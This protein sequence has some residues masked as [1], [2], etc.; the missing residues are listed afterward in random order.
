MGSPLAAHGSR[1][2]HVRQRTQVTGIVD[3]HGCRGQGA[4]TSQIITFTGQI[5]YIDVLSNNCLTGIFAAGVQIGDHYFIGTRCVV[6]GMSRIVTA[7][8]IGSP[9]IRQRTQITGVVDRHGGRGQQAVTSQIITGA[10][11][12]RRNDVLSNNCLTGIF[13]VGVQ[14]GDHYFLGTRGIIAG[15]GSPL[16]A[17]GSRA[18]HVRQRTQVTG[19]VDRHGCRGQG[20]VTSQIITFTGQIRYIDVLS[21]NCLTGIF[22]AGIQIGDDYFLGSRCVVAGMVSP[23][24]AHG[25]RA[26][27]VR[28]RSQLTGVVDRHGGRGLQ[29]VTSQI[30]TGAGQ[31]RVRTHHQDHR[32]FPAAEVARTAC[33]AVTGLNYHDNAVTGTYTG[34]NIVHY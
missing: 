32:V 18:P 1:A 33:S 9:V 7:H 25:L 6:A 12:I 3:R 16:A 22:A 26:P 34:I 20:A 17:H 5:R 30:I 28:Q 21:N 11:Q 13:A 23:L 24:T 10:G 27:R 31:I 15:M 19:I 29:A 4:V 2:P 14:I 8:G